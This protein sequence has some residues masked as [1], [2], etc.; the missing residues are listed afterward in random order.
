MPPTMTALTMPAGARANYALATHYLCGDAVMR[1][2]IHG[3]ESSK[4]V[5][6]LHINGRNDDSF[7]PNSDTINWDPH[8]ALRTTSGGRQSPALGLGHE[9]DHALEDPAREGR[10]GSLP[11]A[12]YDNQEERRVIRGAETHAARTLGEGTRHDHAGATFRVPSPIFA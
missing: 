10:L 2:I 12:R 9:M 5:F 8:R 4:R 11:D 1:G 6:H 3:V 7:D